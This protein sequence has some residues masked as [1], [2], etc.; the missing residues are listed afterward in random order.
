MLGAKVKHGIKDH[1]DLTYEELLEQR[2][3]DRRLARHGDR[4]A[5][6][7]SPTTS[8]R[9]S[10]SG[11]GG[12]MGSMPHWMV[13]KNMHADGRGGDPA[14]PRA[15][16]QADLGE[17]SGPLGQHTLTEHAATVGKPELAPVA[18]LDGGALSDTRVAFI[19]E[20]AAEE[21]AGKAAKGGDGAGGNGPERASEARSER[22]LDELG[23][24]RQPGHRELV[25]VWG[26]S[27][28]DPSSQL[29]AAGRAS[30]AA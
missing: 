20:K 7:S 23:G 15:G 26:T 21:A 16:R 5:D 28:E 9:A 3:V 25:Q 1:C 27:L 18:R 17:G 22:C 10:C 12:H 11:A 13:M 30:S 14:L 6:A 4:A 19:P 2:Y 8:A 29:A 24:Q